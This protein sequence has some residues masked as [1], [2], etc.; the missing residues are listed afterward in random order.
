MENSSLAF[1]L[2]TDFDGDSFQNWND[3]V[4]SRHQIVFYDV[5]R[6]TFAQMSASFEIVE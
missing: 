2:S 6:E 3:Q 1:R 5:R 4:L